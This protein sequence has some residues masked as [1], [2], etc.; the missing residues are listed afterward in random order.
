MKFE[1]EAE[2]I[3][4]PI[5]NTFAIQNN[6]KFSYQLKIGLQGGGYESR[7]DYYNH[8]GLEYESWMESYYDYWEDSSWEFEVYRIDFVLEKHGIKLALEIDGETFHNNDLQKKHDIKK[9]LYLEKNLGYK[10]IHIPAKEVLYKSYHF[11]IRL[12][13]FEFVILFGWLVN[14]VL[15]IKKEKSILI[16]KRGL[17]KFLWS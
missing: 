13:C 9:E 3:A 1:S 11:K 5:I 15:D 4:Y 7:E 6:W 14:Y 10:V 2:R 17:D 16:E 12:D 8:K